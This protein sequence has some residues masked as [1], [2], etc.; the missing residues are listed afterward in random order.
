[1]NKRVRSIQNLLLAAL[2]IENPSERTAFLTKACGTD[3]ELR[4]EIEELLRAQAA[5]GHFLPENPAG[6]ANKLDVLR[7]V[8]GLSKEGLRPPRGEKRLPPD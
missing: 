1:M 3:S 5:A 8:A 7:L 6:R 2:E 4:T